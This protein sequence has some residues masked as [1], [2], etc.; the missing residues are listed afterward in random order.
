MP[1]TLRKIG[2]NAFGGNTSLT[3]LSLPAGLTS[4]GEFAFAYCN[5]ISKIIYSNPSD[6]Q[7][8]PT[9]MQIKRNAFFSC[10]SLTSLSLP[11]GLT[12]IGTSAFAE[13]HNISEISCANPVPPS[14]GDDVFSGVD[15][16][17][18]L[19]SIPTDSYY[20]YLLA[21]QWGAFVQMRES[22]DVS[23]D[24]R[25]GDITVTDSVF[26]ENTEPISLM[27]RAP[28]REDA[29]P[30][31]MGAAVYD[32][33]SVY[34]KKENRVTFFITPKENYEVK[35]VLYNG[36]DVTGELRGGAYST[37]AVSGRGNSFEVIYE[38][39]GEAPVL[40]INQQELTL[41]EGETA[42]LLASITPAD[43]PAEIEWKSSDNG[44]A[45]VD[46]N[47][48]I[49]ATAP[50]VAEI[51]ASASDGSCA[52]TCIVTVEKKEEPITPTLT[53]D[54]Q[55]LTLTEGD[56]ATL[57][58]YITPAD[59]PAQIEWKS[60]DNSVAEV[61]GNGC[62]TAIAPGVAEIIASASDGS[63][64]DTCRVTVETKG[65]TAVITTEEESIE[66]WAA[67]GA[68][69]VH[70]V[71]SGERVT[72]YAV[73]GQAVATAMASGGDLVFLLPRGAV[74]I[75]VTE[76]AKPTKVTL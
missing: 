40:T 43:Y 67:E 70:G 17:T 57:S 18:C 49:T 39:T 30:A 58:A 8:T 19:L 32:G 56:T 25:G 61:D 53:I 12:S 21:Q 76:S 5:N 31:T 24:D 36:E 65:A 66:V 3:S 4:I 15:N 7:N 48:R 33:A 44:V 55:E 2:N 69:T 68:L 35:Q 74:Y 34:V 51:I 72:V 38:W 75:V 63:C 52:D 20:D 62:I 13:C 46:G 37:P 9:P 47:G 6:T 28:R 41:T 64:T 50:G 27:A 29:R 23:T 60:S 11:A 42:T 26:E 10:T 54:Q 22:I 73:S 45:E 71:P 14:L 59:Y 16:E 1:P